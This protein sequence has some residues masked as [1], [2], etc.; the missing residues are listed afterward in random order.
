M[1]STFVTLDPSKTEASDFFKRKGP[2]AVWLQFVPGIVG[3]VVTSSDASSYNSP[4]G[5]PSLR[6]INSIL[7]KS[8]VGN[9]LKQTS[10][11]DEEDRYYP[12]FRGMVDV[13]M[14]G[15]PVLL[16]TIGGIQY[17]LG[18]LNT[19]GRPGFNPDHLETTDMQK[20][21]FES[22]LSLTDRNI[23]GLSQHWNDTHVD[24]L[25]KPFNTELDDPDD[26]RNKINNKKGESV[27][28]DIHGDMIFEGRHG[29][30]IRI[31]SRNVNPYIIISNYNY[32]T[33]EGLRY[34][35]TL[36][37][38]DRGSIRQHFKNDVEEFVL[39]SDHPDRNDTIRTIGDTLYDYD[40]STE[41]VE[42]SG[43][44]NQTLLNSDKITI[45]SR[46]DSIFL[47]ANKNVIVGTGESFIIKSKYD[48]IIDSHHI[49]LGGEA[50][51]Q[52]EPL[53]MGNE[54]VKVLEEMI[55]A[56]GQLYVAATI[57]GVSAPIIGS[58]SPGWVQLDT[59]VRNRLKDIV[60]S[61]HYIENNDAEK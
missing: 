61:F 19:A 39:A 27:L 12:L 25:Q 22:E 17:Y 35:S 38:L 16:C 50:H 11:L 41:D 53:V 5:R 48:C 15:D 7:A 8:H 37:M 20:S 49:Y 1:G 26:Y 24:R 36:A 32:K 45:N 14:V 51:K 54:L 59:M 46:R 4:D 42:N 6:L 23:T 18:P 30:S 60:S 29:N 34:G 52:K 56:I 28:S 10:A 31:G 9:T 43:I 57:G 44:F 58:S 40:Y 13:P 47:S 33:T 55:D 21:F 3:D 2:Q